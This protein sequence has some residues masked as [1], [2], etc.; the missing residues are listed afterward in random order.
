MN[1]TS[2]RNAKIDPQIFTISYVNQ[3][4]F[5][6]SITD[7]NKVA[8]YGKASLRLYEF[9]FEG[10]ET[11]SVKTE[12][13]KTIPQQIPPHQSSIFLEIVRD[14]F[15]INQLQIDCLLEMR[16]SIFVL[17][18]LTHPFHD[19]FKSSTFI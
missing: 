9:V 2:E 19:C 16:V 11:G 7:S 14:Y 18:Q 15:T 8:T 5:Q 12:T 3:K 6:M 10:N 1:S 17:R 13:F 4:V